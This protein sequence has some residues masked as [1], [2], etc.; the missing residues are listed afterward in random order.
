MS[1]ELYKVIAQ[2]QLVRK[3]DRLSLIEVIVGTYTRYNTAVHE[4]EI[5]DSFYL[6]NGLNSL[7]V[8]VQTYWGEEQFDLLSAV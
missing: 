4:H 2:Y 7:Y 5:P 3:I 8:G 6:T 1:T